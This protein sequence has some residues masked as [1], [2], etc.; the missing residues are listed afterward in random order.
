[1]ELEMKIKE[2]SANDNVIV[3]KKEVIDELDSYEYLVRDAGNFL[4]N[5]IIYFF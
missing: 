1:M 3:K 2:K 4:Y 5:Y